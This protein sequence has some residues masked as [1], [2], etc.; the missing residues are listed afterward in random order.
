MN[1]GNSSP[2]ALRPMTSRA[3]GSGVPPACLRMSSAMFW[4]SRVSRLANGS[5]VSSR[6]S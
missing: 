3:I 6:L 4:L 2:P 1:T 5:P